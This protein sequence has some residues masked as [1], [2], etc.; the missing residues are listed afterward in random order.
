MTCLHFSLS[1]RT[2]ASL[3]EGLP[4]VYVCGRALSQTTMEMSR[5]D[6]DILIHP[7]FVSICQL[8]PT[9]SLLAGQF[10]GFP[11][12]SPVSGLHWKDPLTLAVQ[13]F[14]KITLVLR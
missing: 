9:F 5:S 7:P 12:L 13:F 1:A 2:F 11:G 10:L 8:Y 4:I 14:P 6:Q 3:A